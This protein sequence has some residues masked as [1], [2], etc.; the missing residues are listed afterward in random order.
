VATSNETDDT[1]AIIDINGTTI[2]ANDYDFID[3]SKDKD[4]CDK[5]SDEPQAND[6]VVQLGYQGDDAPERQNAIVLAGAGDGSPYIRQYVGINSF[7]LPEPETQIKPNDNVLSGTTRFKD[8]KGKERALNEV[9]KAWDETKEQV[10]N[11]EVGV[12]LLRNTGFTGDYESIQLDLSEKLDES[13]SMFSP[14]L[15]H[16]QYRGV[17]VVENKDSASGYSAILETNCQLKQELFFPIEKGASYILSFKAKSIVENYNP[18]LFFEIGGTPISIHATNDVVLYEEKFTA[19]NSGNMFVLT[20]SRDVE[21]YE[22]A[23]RRG[24]VASSTWEA[25]PLDGRKEQAQYE[26]LSYLKNLLKAD[27]VI[28]G[29]VVSTGVVNTGLINMGHYDENGK[30]TEITAGMSGTYNNDDSVAFFGGGDLAK[31]IYTVKKYKENPNYEPTTEELASMAKV[32]ITHGGRAI[33]NDIILRGYVYAEGGIFRGGIAVDK[34]NMGPFYVA[35]G[36][37]V[38]TCRTT[39]L[40]ANSANEFAIWRDSG[41]SF[42]SEETKENLDYRLNVSIGDR[43]HSSSSFAV[44]S[45]GSVKYDTFTHA[46][47]EGLLV[48]LSCNRKNG[49]EPLYDYVRGITIN[50]EGNAMKEAFAIRCPNG[51]FAG[52]RPRS[53]HIGDGTFITGRKTYSYPIDNLV[54]SVLIAHYGGEC[55]ITLPQPQ[56]GQELIIESMGSNIVVNLNS[57]KMHVCGEYNNGITDEQKTPIFRTG[58]VSFGDNVRAVR[59]KYYSGTPIY[60]DKTGD[61]GA[62]NYK[63]LPAWIATKLQ[64]I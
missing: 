28:D 12:N 58:E 46:F 47:T 17:E 33:L 4:E 50:V 23:L 49:K 1:D 16:W 48:Q 10:E 5:G 41:V 57:S 36:G 7:S 34:G 44:N 24:T 55:C 2:T 19:E 64:V 3:L 13:T 38:L 29:G 30:V 51:M 18:L 45:D 37:D 52:L 9:S 61:T 53:Y 32:V 15:A 22:L 14:S 25:S 40:S 43:T 60:I 39:D 54:S 27:T 42:V 59:L 63:E 8:Y 31:A 62:Y 35:G 6:S 26:S 56:D 21:L 20:T 11:L